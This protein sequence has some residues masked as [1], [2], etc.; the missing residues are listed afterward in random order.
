MLPTQQIT[1]VVLR[2]TA[3]QKLPFEDRRNEILR[4]LLGSDIVIVNW[5]ASLVQDHCFLAKLREELA[6]HNTTT[7][8]VALCE[9]ATNREQKIAA[10]ALAIWLRTFSPNVVVPIFA[11]ADGAPCDPTELGLG[12]SMPDWRKPE[13]FFGFVNLE[14]V[15]P[16]G[17]STFNGQSLI[18]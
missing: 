15:T 7:S 3:C 6:R 4:R 8:H 17:G 18:Y 11:D 1:T 14:K 2:V 12:Y 10:V 13:R 9:L 16:Q 5:D